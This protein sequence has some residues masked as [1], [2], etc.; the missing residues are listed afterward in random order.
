MRAYKRVETTR[1]RI[2]SDA[3]GDIDMT[4]SVR[5]RRAL[6]CLR[7]FFAACAFFLLGACAAHDGADAPTIAHHDEQAVRGAPSAEAPREIVAPALLPPPTVDP[8]DV[9]DLPP[10]PGPSACPPTCPPRPHEQR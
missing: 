8:P 7:P 10:L 2:A 5:A 1:R 4:T 6:G 9:P 3:K